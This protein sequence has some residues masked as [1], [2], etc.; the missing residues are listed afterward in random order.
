M[1][2][3]GYTTLTRM[4]GL[5]REMQTIANNIA[6]ASTHGYRKEGVVFSEHIAG[7]DDAPSLS[8]AAGR[9][10]HTSNLQGGA[11]YTGG[12]FDFAIQGEGFFL[13]ETPDGE[14]LTRA[15]NF[16]PNAAGELV[17]P[18]GMRLLDA[19]GAPIFVPPDASEITVAA[20]GT[21]S[22]NGQPLA[23]IGLWAPENPEDVTRRGGLLFGLENPPVPIE[24]PTILQRHLEKSNVDP[25]G[26]I[27]RMVEVQRAYEMGQSFFDNEDKR[28]RSVLTTL[29][30]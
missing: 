12:S 29:G 5:T 19:G 24:N 20:D 17:T 28:I 15:G 18:D 7:L 3:A 10:R 4:S 11:E 30:R 23:Q 26:E 25:I 1:D 21:M 9:V 22:A 2:N 14:A 8:M 6:N 13:V 16:L 27:S